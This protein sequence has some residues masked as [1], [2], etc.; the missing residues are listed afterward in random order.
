MSDIN[1]NYNLIKLQLTDSLNEKKKLQEEYDNYC[2]EVYKMLLEL[3]VKRVDDCVV[4]YDNEILGDNPISIKL[5]VNE[6][7]IHSISISRIEARY[8]LSLCYN[9]NITDET[10][11]VSNI[12]NFIVD[13]KVFEDEVS[14]LVRKTW[15]YICH[16]KQFENTRKKI[17]EL[18]LS[19]ESMKKNQNLIEK[20]IIIN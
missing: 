16:Y 7:G 10:D 5:I 18:K 12:S 8:V 19:C 11:C 1:T 20:L 9:P 4:K 17:D 14:K 6:I 13:E 3:L 2:N 15:F